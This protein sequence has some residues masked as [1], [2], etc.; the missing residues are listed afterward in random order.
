[1]TFANPMHL[2]SYLKEKLQ[3]DHDRVFVAKQINE[4]R[5]CLHESIKMSPEITAKKDD[6]FFTLCLRFVGGEIPFLKIMSN[7][8]SPSVKAANISCNANNEIQLTLSIFTALSEKAVNKRFVSAE[9]TV[10]DT[11]MF[12]KGLNLSKEDSKNAEFVTKLVVAGNSSKKNLTWYYNTRQDLK[13]R[14]LL[15]CSPIPSIDAFLLMSLR[16]DVKALEEIYIERRPTEKGGEV[17]SIVLNHLEDDPN[18]HYEFDDV[19]LGDKNKKPQNDLKE[20]I[21]SLH[22][23]QHNKKKENIRNNFLHSTV[24]GKVKEKDNSGSNLWQIVKSVFS[25][26]D[27]NSK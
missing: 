3:D 20:K 12:L 10:V 21:L 2:E 16:N 9:E 15:E 8:D 26:N 27:N 6:N 5:L 13:N 24:K 14:F 19:S 23:N 7:F 25:L 17:L 1:M 4:V 11:S 22:S 18:K